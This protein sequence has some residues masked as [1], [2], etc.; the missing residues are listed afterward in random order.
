MQKTYLDVLGLCCSSEIVLIERILYSLEGIKDVSVFVPSKTVIVVHDSALISPFEI[1]KTLNQARLEAN[2]RV[3]GRMSYQKKWPN[4]SV[5]AC[6][7]LLGLSFLKYV[8]SPLGWLAVLAVLV[9]IWPIIMRGTAAVRNLHLDVNILVIIAVAG[10]LALKDFWEAGTIVFLFTIAEWLQSRASHEANAVMSS[11]M[12]IAPQQATIAETG[13]S[14]NVEDVKLGTVLAVITGEV[15]PIDGLVVEGSC[16]LDEKALTGEAF[17]VPKQKEST[18]WAGT[19]N[20]NGYVSVKTS[21]LPEDCVVAKMAKLVEEA[22]NKKPRFQRLIDEIAK[23]YT[24]GQL[25]DKNY[26]STQNPV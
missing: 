9:G 4:G 25:L 8:Y 18:V 23:Y 1:V 22:Q 15:I 7:L 2:V 17:P 20:V 24:P 5:I 6:G 26:F 3:N 11:L 12:N 19:I 16:E 14:V 13:E 21:A 10:T